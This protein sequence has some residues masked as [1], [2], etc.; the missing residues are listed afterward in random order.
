MATVTVTVPAEM[1]EFVDRLVVEHHY[2]SAEEYLLALVKQDQRRVVLQELESQLRKGMEG[3]TVPMDD[4]FWN[5][6]RTQ[7]LEGLTSDKIPS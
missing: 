5:S 1:Q 6:I 3:P 7:A 4:D 2:S